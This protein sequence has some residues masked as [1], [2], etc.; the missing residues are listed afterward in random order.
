MNKSLDMELPASK[1]SGGKP[2]PFEGLMAAE[3]ALLPLNALAWARDAAQNHEDFEPFQTLLDN[4]LPV[5]R[6][7]VDVARDALYACRSRLEDGHE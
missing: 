1:S 3:D 7:Q 6:G 4:L 5:L 2:R